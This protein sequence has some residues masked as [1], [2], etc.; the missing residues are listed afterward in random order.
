MNFI[1]RHLQDSINAELEPREEVLWQ[2]MPT[3]RFFTRGSI[4]SFL[5]G[6]PWTAFA[7]FWMW[8]ASGMGQGE[9]EGPASYFFL[10]G[11]PFVLIGIGMLSSPLW[12]YWKATRTAYVITGRR[13]IVFEGGRGIT[14]RS[15]PPERL[16]S[17]YRKQHNDGSGDVIIEVNAWRDSDGDQQSQT[18]GFLR[19]RNAKQAETLLKTLA[20]EAAPQ[21]S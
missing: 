3:P 21:R 4:A 17:V 20:E 5:F 2:E 10:F 11:L 12:A 13:A 18:L 15:Y 19:I 14:V 7:L 8:G 16:Q 9:F 6:I 1:P